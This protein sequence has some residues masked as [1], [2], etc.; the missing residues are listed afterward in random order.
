MDRHCDL[1]RTFPRSKKNHGPV[2]GRP[3]VQGITTEAFGELSTVFLNCHGKLLG[4]KGYQIKAT[5]SERV[6][7]T[8]SRRVYEVTPVLTQPLTQVVKVGCRGGRVYGG[9]VSE[10][11]LYRARRNARLNAYR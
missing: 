2:E 10:K 11:A 7:H 5:T 6:E 1:R 4:L 8:P 9:G 3:E